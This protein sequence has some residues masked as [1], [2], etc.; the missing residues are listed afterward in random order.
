MSSLLL[1]ILLLASYAEAFWRMNCNIIQIGRVDPI[2]NPGALAQHAHTISG[3]SNVGV[4]ATYQSLVNS[5]CN[6]CEIFPD[7]SAYWT[8]NLY[9]AR[10]NGSFEEV[11]HTGSVIYYLGRGYLPDGS[12][13]FTPFP[14]G[15]MMVS[16]NKS[17][18]RYNAT[19]NT[20]G[21]ATYPSRP[22]QDAVS[23][24]C[25][26]EII[27]PETPNLVNVPSCI[28]GL[29][30]QIHFQSCWN[31]RDLYR[32][33]NSHVAYLSGVDNGVCPP[34]YPILLP[35]IFMETN[36][37]VRLTKNTDD[38]GRF[39]FSMGD[40]TGYGFHGD[41]QNGWD[42]ALQKKAV[43]GC[44]AD[45]GFGT[46][47]ECPILQ[48]NRNTQFGINCP[49]M[50][51]QV[52]E[53]ARGMLDKLPGC[54]RITSGP[55]SATATDME[56]PANAPRPSISRTVDSTPLPTAN[57]GIGQTFGNSFNKYVGCGNDSTGSPLRT[58]NAL[59]TQ[60]DGLTVGKCQTFCSSKGYRYSGVE[61]GR[62]CHCDLAINPT[63]QFYAGVNMSTGCS[64]TCPGDRTELCGGP[65]YMNVY[66]NT[67]PAFVATNDTSN[68]VFQLTVAPAPYGD[69]YVG[70]Y[71]EGRSSR[72]LAGIS[73]ASDKM[74][75]D[76][77][78]DYC[79]DYK[80]YGTEFGSQCF[81]SN[82]IGTTTGVRRLDTL[83][84]PRFS[85]CN[86]RCNGNFSQICGGSGTIN[87]WENKNYIPVVVKASSGNYK[88]KQCYTD[89]GSGR[90]LDTARTVDSAMTVDICAA[91]AKER[92]LKYFGV[93][94]GTECYASNNPQKGTGFAGVTC[95][96]ER[97]M[98]CG[99]NKYEYCGGPS[100]MNLY[101]ATNP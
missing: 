63:T 52:A 91:F 8:P 101:F 7:K 59:S 17:N 93:E 67:D 92:G 13:K 11:Y 74:S 19:G 3:G 45:S 87:I 73:S 41:F 1:N 16:G 42:V 39:V 57:P 69:N 21:N 82:I 94:Y 24:A 53:P 80:Y 4:N 25:L 44:I 33:D 10:P 12:Q 83:T 65:S 97:L 34:G 55:E 46:I 28:N 79:R 72:V 60:M 85:S 30:A 99:G 86:Y 22:I 40:T 84:E 23:Y 50:P 31:G 48:A 6:S 38:G 47:E 5:A 43:E 18:R 100:L 90:A 9:Y 58:L 36:Y 68:S 26:S 70:C 75:V 64:M 2:I 62:E 81:C 49:E 20:W 61:Y 35:H 89:A 29:R 76:Q 77:C 88:A 15:F 51:P 14:K 54:I 95:P 98:P 37:A 96:I 27:G 56:C 32:S 78:A 71:S 66:N